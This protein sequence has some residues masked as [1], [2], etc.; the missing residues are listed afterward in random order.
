MVSHD[1]HTYIR[2][3]PSNMLSFPIQYCLV[4]SCCLRYPPTPSMHVFSSSFFCFA[5]PIAKISITSKERLVAK[6]K[7]KKKQGSS[8]PIFNEAVSCAADMDS[9]HDIQI[10]VTLLN[11]KKHGKNRELG[12]VVL[13]SKATGNELRHWNDAITSPGKHI[14]EWHD[15]MCTQN[16]S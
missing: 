16:T 1:I 3:F 10:V 5:D 9:I 4:L 7:T 11:E 14:A 12:K 6:L 2:C 13:G 15:L 8:S